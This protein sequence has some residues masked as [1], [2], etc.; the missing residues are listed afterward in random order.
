MVHLPTFTTVALTFP[1][2]V[3]SLNDFPYYFQ[4]H[5]LPL[6]SFIFLPAI[7]ALSTSSRLHWVS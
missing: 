1:Y 4:S 5:L 7:N 6:S 3:K 2:M